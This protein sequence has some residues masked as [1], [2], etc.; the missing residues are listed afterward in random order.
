MAFIVV[1]GVQI[2]YKG[3]HPS[4]TWC[5]TVLDLCSIYVG[6]MALTLTLYPSQNRL[7]M[8]SIDSV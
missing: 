5:D 3:V 7:H 1:A 8:F 2:Q 6:K 4:K